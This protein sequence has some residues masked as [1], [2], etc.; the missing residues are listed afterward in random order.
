MS[1]EERTQKDLIKALDQ[2]TRA[3]EELVKL[4]KREKVVKPRDPAQPEGTTKLKE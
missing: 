2:N 4:L 1:K 3:T